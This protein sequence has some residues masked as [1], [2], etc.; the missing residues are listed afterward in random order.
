MNPAWQN[1]VEGYLNNQRFYLLVE[2][3]D[4]DPAL[5]VWRQDGENRKA[6]GVGLI[7]TGKLEKYDE[8]PAGSLAEVVTSASIWAKRICEYGPGQRCICARNIRI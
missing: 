6:R 7:N 4:F 3:E 5:S 1:A 8:V 2:P